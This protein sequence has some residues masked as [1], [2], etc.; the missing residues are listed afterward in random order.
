M[1]TIGP[2][3]VAQA[4]TLF[5]VMQTVEADVDS[6]AR[7]SLAIGGAVVSEYLSARSQQLSTSIE[8][9]AADFGLKE[10]AAG[11]DSERS[12]RSSKITATV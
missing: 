7:E 5:A 6:R 8:V 2:L 11:G 4:V 12:V 1:L 10:A 9:L 3:A